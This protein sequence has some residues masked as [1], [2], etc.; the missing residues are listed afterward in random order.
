MA[1]SARRR[2]TSAAAGRLVL[3]ARL[4][5]LK[6][7]EFPLPG[8]SSTTS[9]PTDTG[10]DRRNASRDDRACRS[11]WAIPRARATSTP[12]A[13]RARTARRATRSTPA[14]RAAA[15]ATGAGRGGT[16]TACTSSATPAGRHTMCTRVYRDTYGNGLEAYTDGSYQPRWT[17]AASQ[18]LRRPHRRRLGDPATH[19]AAAPGTAASTTRKTSTASAT[20][21][22]DQGLPR[23]HHLG[24]DRGPHRPDRASHLRVGLGHDRREP[25][26]STSGPPAAPMP[27]TPC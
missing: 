18:H 21:F 23:C 22:A 13:T 1:A 10:K 4:V 24:G 5:D 8:A 27:P 14:P 9:A 12:S 2:S 3:P 16:R 6:A 11:S 7:D 15:S 20:A 17:T 25:S 19:R 26:A